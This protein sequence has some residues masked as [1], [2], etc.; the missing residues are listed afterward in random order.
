MADRVTLL[1]LEYFESFDGARRRLVQ[2]VSWVEDDE[3][4]KVDEPGG[5]LEELRTSVSN[6]MRLILR[7]VFDNVKAASAASSMSVPM[8][9]RGMLSFAPEFYRQ[10]YI[11]D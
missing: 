8:D 1:A 10:W 9:V 4:E 3:D 5:K 6:N 7:S 11:H 2:D